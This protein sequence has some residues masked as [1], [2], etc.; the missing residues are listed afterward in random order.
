MANG[1]DPEMGAREDRRVILSTRQWKVLDAIAEI[2]RAKDEAKVPN[3]SRV[4]RRIVDQGLAEEH[5][6][7]AGR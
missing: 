1:V 7:G 3:V 6:K 5:R 2:E 4:L